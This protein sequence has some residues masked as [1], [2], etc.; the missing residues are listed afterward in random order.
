MICPTFQSHRCCQISR[1]NEDEIEPW[2][3]D[4]FGN[5]VS[6]IDMFDSTDGQ[7]FF[8]CAL[9]VISH[10]QPPSHGRIK[11]SPKAFAVW[12]ITH[13]TYNGFCGTTIR[14]HRKTYSHR[15]EIK[16]QFCVTSVAR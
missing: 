5:R 7:H 1:S 14:G 3:R 4:H 8:V 6:S 9:K 15:P 10:R 16:R 11:R 13:C 2:S 12:W